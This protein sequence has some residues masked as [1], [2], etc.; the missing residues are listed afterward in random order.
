MKHRLSTVVA[1]AAVGALLAGCGGG[2]PSSGGGK[3]SDDKIVL[4]VLTDLSGV[5]ADIAGPNSVQAVQMAV[6]DFKKKYGDKAIT[7]NIEVIKADHQNKPEIA[8]TQAREMYDRKKADALFDVPT[9]SAA[10]AVQTVAGQAKKLYFNT[11]AAT[12]ELAGKTCNPYTYEWAYDTYMLAHGTG[13]A[14]TRAGGKNWY[15]IYPDYAF[16][17]DM[18]KKFETAIEGAGGKVVAKDPTPFPSDNYST[19]LLKAPGLKPKPQVLGALQAGGDLANVVKQYQQFKL[20][21]KGIELAIGLLFDTD[22]KAIGADKLA[23][24]M[25]TTAWFWNVDAKAQA[26]ADRFK[27]RTGQRPT[28]DQAADYSA[29]THYLEAA[30]KAGSDRAADVSKELDGTKFSDFFAHN[31][32]IRAEDHRV[33]HDAY[34]AKVKDPAKASEAGDYTE[35][36][37]T[38]PAAEAFDQPSP[39][40]HLS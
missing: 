12:T 16:G 35:P 5:Y 4:G 40:C 23:G 28:F 3:V 24:T 13:S 9:S 33:V 31:A 36:V 20:K 30:Q 2:G 14:V 11:G 22:I 27:E 39:D 34:L 19:F 21:D 38:I 6:D 7:R 18:Q 8:N 29:A 32:T 15:T 1:T 37:K 26:W 25:F 17:Q 10:L